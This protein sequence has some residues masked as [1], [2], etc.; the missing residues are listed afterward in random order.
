MSKNT[1]VFFTKNGR[2]ESKVCA[3]AGGGG[4]NTTLIEAGI[5]GSKLL[6]VSISKYDAA[7]TGAELIYNDGTT[8]HVL[9]DIT[10]A[11]DFNFLD[12]NLFPKDR[13]GN[14]YL[15]MPPNSSIIIKAEGTVSITVSAY[16]EDY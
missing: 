15:N 14:N 2:S 6:G 1:S 16:L 10:P 12:Y 4:S 11:A 8:D 5:D 3:A 7:V 13:N 9:R